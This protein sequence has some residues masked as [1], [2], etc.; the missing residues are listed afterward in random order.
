MS[1]TRLVTST[2]GSTS[3]HIASA[4]L[5]TATNAQAA[6]AIFDTAIKQLSTSRANI[7]AV[8]NRMQVAISDLATTQTNLTAANSR[9]TDVDVASETANMTRE[10]ILSQAGV[11]VL[12]QANQL[13]SAALSLLRG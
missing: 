11:A 12:S 3:L 1:I 5:S 7:G 6:L 9:I 8:Q 2:L 13:P 4:S 10:N